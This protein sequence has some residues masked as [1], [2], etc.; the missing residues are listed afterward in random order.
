MLRV[1]TAHVLMVVSFARC[2]THQPSFELRADRDVVL[3]AMASSGR[4]SKSVSLASW[5]WVASAGT[6]P[7][8]IAISRSFWSLGR[9]VH[10]LQI[11]DPLRKVIKEPLL[12]LLITTQG[13]PRRALEASHERPML[14]QGPKRLVHI[15]ERIAHVHDGI[16]DHRICKCC[17]LR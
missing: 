14:A 11:S 10:L 12:L 8:A 2:S 13:A 3:T 9:I 4:C 7:S 5:V 6:E 17:G 15:Q 1:E 16:P